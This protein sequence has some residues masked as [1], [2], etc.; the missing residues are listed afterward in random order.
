MYRLY[1]WY[2][3]SLVNRYRRTPIEL[4]K[5]RDTPKTIRLT[6]SQRFRKK[7]LTGYEGGSYDTGVQ[8]KHPISRE[9][10]GNEAGKALFM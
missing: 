10:I 8:P 1:S 5:P 4:G 6:N 3:P 7:P 2:M 9:S